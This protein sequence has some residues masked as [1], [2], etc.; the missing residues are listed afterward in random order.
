M[1][2][3][4]SRKRRSVKQK[5]RPNRKNGW[6]YLLESVEVSNFEGCEG[7]KTYKYGATT[8]HF[9]ERCKRINYCQKE[10]TFFPIAAFR[11]NDIYADENYVAHN[12]ISSGFARISEYLCYSEFTDSNYV[13]K[14]FLSFATPY[15]ERGKEVAVVAWEAGV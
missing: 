1:G 6:V 3:R 5:P 11:S 4:L 15:K 2:R 13:R 10:L 8:K 7:V 12:L 14:R 9:T